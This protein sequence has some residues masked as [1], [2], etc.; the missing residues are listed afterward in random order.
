MTHDER[1]AD[2]AGMRL[3]AA[4]R[5]LPREHAPARDLWPQ[6]AARIDDTR[7]L[8]PAAS[9]P[10]WRWQAAAAVLLVAGSS[11]VTA[12]LLGRNEPA[13]QVVVTAPPAATVPAHA[14]VVAMPAAFGPTG[15]L[16]PEYLAAREQLTQVL[17]QRIAALP[18]STR[19]KLELN[20][21]EMRR[22]ADAI[23]D[24]LAG[25]PGD[26]LLEE[27][28]LNTYQDEL[29]MLANVNQLTNSLGEAQASP[30]AK[31]MQL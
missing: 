26:P 10:A 29:A 20:L 6:I 13:G 5:E 17:E 14:E 19:A 23:N 16:D 9:R 2:V 22:A 1:E 30:T 27:L 25:Q 11:L 4:L 28:L 3:D 18:P 12:T 24:A 15:T 8:A 31:G 7:A 21:A